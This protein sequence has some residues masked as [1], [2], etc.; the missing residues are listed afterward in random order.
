M[1]FKVGTTI[2]HNE[3][4]TQGIILEYKVL[5]LSGGDTMSCYVVESILPECYSSSDAKEQEKIRRKN[6]ATCCPEY[7]ESSW[8]QLEG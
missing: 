8:S 1:K 2:Q 4:P 5:K 3:F 7:I 6:T